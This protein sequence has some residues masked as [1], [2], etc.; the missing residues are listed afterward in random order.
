M[1]LKTTAKQCSSDV[2]TVEGTGTG[3]ISYLWQN[4]SGSDWLNFFGG[5]GE[6]ASSYTTVAEDSSMDGL[7]IHALVTNGLDVSVASNTVTL[8]VN[9]PSMTATGSM[10]VARDSQ[11]AKLLPNDKV[12]VTGGQ[13]QLSPQQRT[14]R[15]DSTARSPL[16]S[17]RRDAPITSWLCVCPGYERLRR[18]ANFELRGSV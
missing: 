5:T 11:T 13:A 17:H 14:Q 3:T 15:P 9:A 12:L 6:F 2:F 8:T 18:L 10:S 1:P 7:L 16:Y 4:L